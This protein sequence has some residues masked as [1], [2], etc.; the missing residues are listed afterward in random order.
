MTPPKM[1]AQEMRDGYAAAL[2]A[3]RRV[4]TAVVPPDTADSLI[5]LKAIGSSRR[6]WGGLRPSVIDRPVR[7]AAVRSAGAVLL[8]R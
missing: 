8:C 1:A 5:V 4:S 6:C 3:G 7:R 2:D